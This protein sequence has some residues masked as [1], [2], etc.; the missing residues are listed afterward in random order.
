MIPRSPGLSVTLRSAV[1][2]LGREWA[3]SPDRPRPSPEVA[4][5]WDRVVSSWAD[6]VAVPLLVRKHDRRDN[7]RGSAL[8]HNTGRV[9]V[10]VDNAAA[11]W[12]MANALLGRRPTLAELA[13]A[14]DEHRLPVA[15]ILARGEGEGARCRGLLGRCDDTPDLNDLGWKVAHLR[16]VGLRQRAKLTEVP[17]GA[18]QDHMRRLLSPSNMILVPKSHG[19]LAEVPEF[20]AA[21]DTSGGERR[22]I[23]VAP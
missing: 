7:R 11:N 21:F 5:H 9:L 20:L 18:L 1:L 14:L 10:P 16:A 22:P 12:C 4:A 17:L 8:Q 13:T 3:T 15:M 23:E 6:D 2:E 19:A